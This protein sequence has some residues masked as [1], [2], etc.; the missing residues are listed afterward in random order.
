MRELK[1]ATED[2]YLEAIYEY[3]KPV[4][5]SRGS[6]PYMIRNNNAPRRGTTDKKIRNATL[7]P[8]SLLFFPFSLLSFSDH[9]VDLV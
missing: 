7:Y 5:Y 3:L 6:V 2:P 9:L 4:F 1:I 8:P